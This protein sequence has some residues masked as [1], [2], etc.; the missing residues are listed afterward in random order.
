[1]YNNNQNQAVHNPYAR[2]QSV[3]VNVLNS[4]INMSIVNRPV[5]N[6]GNQRQNELQ[7][8][9]TFS[10]GDQK[11][12]ESAEFVKMKHLPFYEVKQSLIKQTCL[13]ATRMV[14]ADPRNQKALRCETQYD[15]GLT[16]QQCALICGSREIVKATNKIDYGYQLQLRFA[17]HNT[18]SEQDD[19]FPPSLVLKVNNRPVTLPAP[20]PSNY[21][22]TPARQPS[23]PLNI[24]SQAKLRPIGMISSQSQQPSN[25]IVV[26][27]Q[28]DIMGRSWVVSLNLV[29][30]LNSADLFQRL[31][32]K[33]NMQ[34]SVTGRLIDS[35][36]KVD[37]F[38][39][40]PTNLKVSV[41]CPVGKSRM[42]YPCRS[43][44]CSHIQCFDARLYLQ[45]NEKKPVWTCPVCN[46]KILYDDLAIDGF[47]IQVI[48]DLPSVACNDIEINPDGSWKQID[49]KQEN[50]TNTQSSGR[51]NGN[52][53]G[54]VNTE[55]ETISIDD[56]S[57]NEGS[58]PVK[59]KV[60]PATIEMISLSDSEDE[61]PKSSTNRSNSLAPD[62][63]KA[64][65]A[66]ASST[67]GVNPNLPIPTTPADGS[68]VAA[69]DDDDVI[70]LSD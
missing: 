8:R 61:D 56:D 6:F 43:T 59:E 69:D 21:P 5:T 26:S 4:G 34:P 41:A 33:G 7:W 1:M 38:E 40:A 65:P 13:F 68:S 24:T 63:P 70:C 15:F 19:E 45:M 60:P 66:V 17:V 36:M 18:A 10:G 46:K 32:D 27:W 57:D 2:F 11:A 50:E 3:G 64:A 58:E 39:M 51:P 53:T 44:A 9:P 35:I 48:K 42:E 29:K 30:K 25:S 54:V 14:P 37:E 52:S 23:K 31:K 55:I 22:G 20:I 49:A 47:F 28:P 67:K 62:A 16:L 12:I